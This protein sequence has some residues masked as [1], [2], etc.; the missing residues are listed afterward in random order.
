MEPRSTD[1]TPG[2]FNAVMADMKLRASGLER[3]EE[4]RLVLIE[5]YGVD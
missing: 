4:G 3:D 1:L 5:E 2:L